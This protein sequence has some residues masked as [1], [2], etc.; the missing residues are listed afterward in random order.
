MSR[1]RFRPTDAFV[2]ESIRGQRYLMGYVLIEARHLAMVRK[3]VVDL[4]VGGKRLHFHQELDAT[5]RAALQVFAD[6]PIEVHVVSVLR[7]HEVTEF[8]ARNTCLARIVEMVQERSVPLL[9]IESRQDDHDDRVT[10]VRHRQPEPRLI[11]D[12]RE[13]AT[14]PMLWIADGVLWSL[15]AGGRWLRH[16]EPIVRTLTE[17]GR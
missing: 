15:G 17:L 6:L 11:F 13:G 9:T 1:Q 5:R 3:T 2:D 7:S 4:V 12:H 10:I 16:V 14:E 8:E